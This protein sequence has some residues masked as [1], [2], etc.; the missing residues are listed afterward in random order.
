MSSLG[1]PRDA[2]WGSSRQ[3]FLSYSH[4]HDKFLY[5]IP[6]DI[7]KEDEDGFL[8]IVDRLKELIKYKGFQVAPAT[9]EDILLR[10]D[11]VADVGVVGVQ[12][13]EAGELPK[14]FVVKK[15]DVTE[16]ELQDFVSGIVYSL[17]N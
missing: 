9:L 5:S 12:D 8:Y 15:T 16:K 4:T 6:G 7:G 13:L 1:K 3:I 2:K 11:A 17:I 10:H 14:A